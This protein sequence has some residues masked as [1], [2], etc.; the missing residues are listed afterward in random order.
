MTKLSVNI[1]KIATLRNSRGGNT[2]NLLQVAT[3]IENFGAQGITIH[4]RPD[5][6]HIRYQDAYDLK[7]IVTTEYNIEGNPIDK[8]MKMVLEIKPTQV[9][10]VP[11]SVATLT[12]N[13]GW[14][15]VANQ[16]YLQEVITEFKNNNI[17]TSIFIDTD[18]K[19]IEAAAKTGADRIEL[20]TEE[21]ATQYALGN[22][23]AIKPYTDAAI[24][25][26][27]LGLG[28]NAGHD[29]SLENIQFFKENIPNLA[30][31]SIGHALISESLYLGLENVVN[32]Y[33]DRLK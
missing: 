12:S 4:P 2:P 11:D 6:R 17:R 13:A 29:L 24:L 8:F 27:K 9:T 19:L 1:N 26:H 3:D 25:A 21:F 31:V 23:Q 28:I 33:L 5:E 20:Y 7:S 32:M 18:L 30:E 10:L 14:D 16:S 22:K 15:T